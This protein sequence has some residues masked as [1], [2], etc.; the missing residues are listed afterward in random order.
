MP[1]GLAIVLSSKAGLAE[2]PVL[3]DVALVMDGG[4]EP[5]V[6]LTACNGERGSGL[7]ATSDT[8]SGLPHSRQDTSLP[9]GLRVD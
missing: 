4:P 6:V 1:D 7:R 5:D 9:S 8:G 2:V 3:S